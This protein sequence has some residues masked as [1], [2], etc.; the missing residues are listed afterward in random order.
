MDFAYKTI[1][2]YEKIVGY[3]VGEAFRVGWNMARTTNAMLGITPLEDAVEQAVRE[4]PSGCSIEIKVENGAGWVE[5][6][7]PYPAPPRLY[8]AADWSLSQLVLEALKDAKK[9]KEEG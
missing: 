4:L 2:E 1:E 6:I 7:R 8:M 9:E 5:L 3:E